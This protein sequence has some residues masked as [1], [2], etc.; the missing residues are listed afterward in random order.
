[1]KLI[2]RFM[3]ASH[4]PSTSDRL[5]VTIGQSVAS[6]ARSKAKICSRWSERDAL[7]NKPEKRKMRLL[8]EHDNELGFKQTGHSLDRFEESHRM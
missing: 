6:C 7:V 1:M 5:T 3:V 8:A 4:F 2:S